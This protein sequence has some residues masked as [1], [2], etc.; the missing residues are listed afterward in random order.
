MEG[1]RKDVDDGKQVAKLL[2]LIIG[3]TLN[4]SFSWYQHHD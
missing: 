2:E 1:E 3:V 4:A